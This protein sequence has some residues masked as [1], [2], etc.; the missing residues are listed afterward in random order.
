MIEEAERR[1][2][3]TVAL[4]RVLVRSAERAYRYHLFRRKHG[5]SYE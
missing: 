1:M 2:D 4:R 3:E 5:M